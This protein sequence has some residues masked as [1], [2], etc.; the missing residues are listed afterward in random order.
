MYNYWLNSNETSNYWIEAS[1]TN[2][3]FIR[4]NPESIAGQVVIKCEFIY[5]YGDNDSITGNEING[6]SHWRQRR[7]WLI[8]EEL[9]DSIVGHLPQNVT[10]IWWQKETNLI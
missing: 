3:E 2:A 7:H 5:I 4:I 1:Q 9:F 8:R 10:S 6:G